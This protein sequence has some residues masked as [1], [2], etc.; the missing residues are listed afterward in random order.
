MEYYTKIGTVEVLRRRIYALDAYATSELRSTVIVEPG[1]FDVFSSGLTTFWMMSG[2]LNKRGMWSMGDGLS[3]VIEGDTPSGIRVNFPSPRF[4]PDEWKKLL[5]EPTC[6]EGHPEQRLRF[7]LHDIR[8]L[9]TRDLIE[10]NYDGVC[11]ICEVSLSDHKW[12]DL[13]IN[14]FVVNCSRKVEA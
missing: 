9:F 12:A 7:V 1:L 3:M 13:D 11:E 14:G 6:T 8:R 10:F 5:K 2:E 4:G